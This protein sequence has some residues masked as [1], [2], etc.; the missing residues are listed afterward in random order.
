MGDFM[1]NDRINKLI[2][3]L[4]LNEFNAFY[5]EDKNKAVD[6]ISNICSGKTVGIGDSHTIKEMG[7][8]EKLETITKKLSACQLDKSRKN[9]LKS[10]S[11]DVFILSANAISEETGELVNI[12]SSC[13]RISGSLYGPKEVIFVI[14]T[15]KIANNLSEAIYRARNIAAPLNAKAHNYN[16]PCAKT[17][18]CENCYTKDRIVGLL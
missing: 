9:K 7:L 1:E 13:N 2:Q 12:D 17:G 3:K 11:S 15:N 6:F 8:I 16:T 14:G 10:I 4:K 5:F 18:K